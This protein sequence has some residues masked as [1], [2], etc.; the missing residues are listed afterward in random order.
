MILIDSFLLRQ[1]YLTA[2]MAKGYDVQEHIDD[3]N[4]LGKLLNA[5]QAS[6]SEDNSIISLLKK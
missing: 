6:F 5:L 2:E 1:L 3:L 4:N